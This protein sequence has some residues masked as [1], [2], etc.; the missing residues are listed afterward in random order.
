MGRD[1]Y[2]ILGVSKTA[3]D[4]ELKRAY[5]KL[6]LKWHPDRNLDNQDEANARFKEISEAYDVLT[7]PQKRQI[8]DAYGEEGLK[9]GA[10]APGTP[11]GGGFSGFGPGVSRGGG[12]YHMDEEAARKL[13]ESLFGG[14]LGGGFSFGGGGGPRRMYTG[15]SKRNRTDGA[16][17]SFPL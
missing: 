2:S 17:L 16:F 9:G 13:F 3:T 4:D 12:G 7:D 6:A 11:E 14:G 15:A 8:Y 1:Y 10:P 5:R